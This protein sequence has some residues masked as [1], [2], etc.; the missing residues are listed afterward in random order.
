MGEGR[1]KRTGLVYSLPVAAVR[2]GLSYQTTYRLVVGGKLGE[3]QH[4]RGRWYVPVKAVNE[5]R[6]DNTFE[7]AEL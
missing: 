3:P 6:R 4:R 7:V 5:Y 1:K 2:L